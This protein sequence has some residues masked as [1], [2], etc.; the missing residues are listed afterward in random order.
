MPQIALF[1]MPG[2]KNRQ[3][4]WLNNFRS[5]NCCSNSGALNMHTYAGTPD[6]DRIYGGI[7]LAYASNRGWTVTWYQSIGNWHAGVTDF[8][9]LDAQDI[10]DELNRIGYRP[11]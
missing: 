6:L 3:K 9:F 4:R 7:L 2:R 1:S 5:G 11:L 8:I 10:A